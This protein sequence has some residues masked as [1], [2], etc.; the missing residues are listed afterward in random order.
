MNV[1]SVVERSAVA[2]FR[3][4]KYSLERGKKRHAV[5]GKRVEFRGW[6][7][8]TRGWKEF[9]LLKAELVRQDNGMGAVACAEL[10]KD[11]VDMRLDRGLT[12]K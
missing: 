12:Y 9:F 6:C 4:W 7:C 11:V 8:S 2:S 5:V 10:G 3:Y 1:F